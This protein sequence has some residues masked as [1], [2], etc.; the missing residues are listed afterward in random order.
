MRP[1]ANPL[2]IWQMLSIR[3]KMAL[4]YCALLGLLLAGFGFV[5]YLGLSTQLEAQATDLARSRAREVAGL[6]STSPEV[7]LQRAVDGFAS[8]GVYVQVQRT[9]G[10]SAV[11]SANL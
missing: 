4:A 5:V 7:P 3:W 1:R 10:E 11:R 8:P 2:G 9:S 6:L